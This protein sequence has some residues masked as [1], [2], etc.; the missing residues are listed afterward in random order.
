MPHITKGYGQI[1]E[2]QA[3]KIAPRNLKFGAIIGRNS[4][5]LTIK[6]KT[7]S[8]LQARLRQQSRLTQRENARKALDHDTP[9]REAPP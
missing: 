9:I 1:G 2:L 4:R 6:C 5:I 3:P 8:P 7:T